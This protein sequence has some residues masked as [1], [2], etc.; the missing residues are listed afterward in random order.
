[1]IESTYNWDWLVDGL[2]EA[3]YRGPL[4]NPAAMQPYSGLKYMDDEAD[5]RWLAHL[6]R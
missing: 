2:L 4:A 5:A 3:A 1:M 6:V